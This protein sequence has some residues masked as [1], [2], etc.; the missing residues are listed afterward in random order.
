M[1]LLTDKQKAQVVLLLLRLHR[2][3]EEYKEK[4]LDWVYKK[5]GKK[6]KPKFNLD[7]FRTEEGA[8][9]YFQWL[10]NQWFKGKK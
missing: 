1:K 9:E 8:R 4:T 5:L 7:T 2:Q 6:R 3:Y 10:S